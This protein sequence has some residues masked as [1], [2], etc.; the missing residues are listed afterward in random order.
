MAAKFD[1][2]KTKTPGVYRRGPSYVVRYRHQG[3]E[4]KRYARTLP[5]LGVASGGSELGGAEEL[6]ELRESRR[7]SWAILFL[8]EDALLLPGDLGSQLLDLLIHAQQHRHHDLTTLV[9]D[10][11]G[12]SALHAVGFDNAGL[13]P[14]AN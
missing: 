8:L 6:Y 9:V 1:L 13:C 14:P 12:L 5:R 3:R 4:R 7:S 2:E 11:L 10:R